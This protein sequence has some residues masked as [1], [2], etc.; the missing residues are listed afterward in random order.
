MSLLIAGLVFDAR[1]PAPPRALALDDGLVFVAGEEL[2]LISGAELPAAHVALARERSNTGRV[3]YVEAE[4][5]GGVGAQ[6]S[7]D[8]NSAS[9][10]SDRC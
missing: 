3:V 10:R 4:S 2:N 8:G 7:G 9:S 5:F 6:A 1:C